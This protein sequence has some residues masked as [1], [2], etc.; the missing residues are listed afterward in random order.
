MDEFTG[1]QCVRNTTEHKGQAC[2][3]IFLGDK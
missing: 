1:R 3:G 2:E